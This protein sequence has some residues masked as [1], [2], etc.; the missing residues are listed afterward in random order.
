MAEDWG[1]EE[2]GSRVGGLKRG[3]AAGR[4]WVRGETVQ[5]LLEEGQC[6]KV[7]VGGVN[8]AIGDRQVLRSC[9]VEN[10]KLVEK[11]G[12]STPGDF[13]PITVTSI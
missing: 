3:T 5:G 11:C 12:K 9:T 1:E 8:G 2:L 4:D 13:R 7:L 10:M 6:R